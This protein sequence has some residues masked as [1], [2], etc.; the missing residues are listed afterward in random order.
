[1]EDSIMA[2]VKAT[3]IIKQSELDFVLKLLDAQKLR[4]I[5]EFQ[6]EKY[7]EFEP[8]FRQYTAKELDAIIGQAGNGRDILLEEFKAK[9]QL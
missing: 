6:V 9:H 1:M 5:V 7:P 2:G 4:G 3:L 8:P